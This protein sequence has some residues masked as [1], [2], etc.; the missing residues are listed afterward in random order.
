MIR[1]ET[2]PRADKMEF[3]VTV[4]SSIQSQNALSLVQYCKP[5][6]LSRRVGFV[7]SQPALMDLDFV[8]DA[9]LEKWETRETPGREGLLYQHLDARVAYDIMAYY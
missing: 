6:T 5:D 3:R 9:F 8:I 4:E 1:R 2:A 7:L